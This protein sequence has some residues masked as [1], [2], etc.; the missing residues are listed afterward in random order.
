M[1]RRNVTS[2]DFLACHS[3]GGFT[4]QHHGVNE[5]KLNGGAVGELERVGVVAVW[6]LPA[7]VR[8][9]GSVLHLCLGVANVLC[10][11]VCETNV[12]HTRV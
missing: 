6:H 7:V 4:S 10:V 12:F 8:A 11:C 3:H 1:C 2:L 5:H 9:L